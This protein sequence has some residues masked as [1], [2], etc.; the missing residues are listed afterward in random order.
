MD[1]SRDF[2]HLSRNFQTA[3]NGVVVHLGLNGGSG[4]A[5]EFHRPIQSLYT[6]NDTLISIENV[7]GTH[8]DDVIVG[9]EKDNVLNGIVGNDTLDGGLGNDTLIGELPYRLHRELCQP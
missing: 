5:T 3:N 4:S 8:S 7:I 2:V 9:N 1:Y 6:Y